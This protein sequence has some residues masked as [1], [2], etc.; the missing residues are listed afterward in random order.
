M[1][2]ESEI[3]AKVWIGPSRRID[4]LSEGRHLEMRVDGVLI[5]Y[6]DDTT[7]GQLDDIIDAAARLIEASQHTPERKASAP[8]K[9]G[10]A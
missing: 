4:R 3:R 1:P 8:P 7:G 9:G 5:E 6:P 2:R 10:G